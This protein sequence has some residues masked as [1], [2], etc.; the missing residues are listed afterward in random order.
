MI[1]FSKISLSPSSNI[2]NIIDDELSKC[3]ES[4]PDISDMTTDQG[5]Q[6]RTP[7]GLS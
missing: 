2:S 1:D 4:L 6:T 7:S 3:Y 5:H